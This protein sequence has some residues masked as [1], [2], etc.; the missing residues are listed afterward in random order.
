[1]TKQEH[2]YAEILRAIAD[3][4]EV[5]WQDRHGQWK[6]QAVETTLTEV[7]NDDYESNR[8]RVKPKLININGFYVPEPMCKAPTTSTLVYLAD[9]AGTGLVKQFYAGGI[10]ELMTMCFESGLVHST[11]EAAVIHAKALL[12]FTSNTKE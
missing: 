12:S 6:Y 7:A 5:Q 1:M 9:P 4:E 2:P 11:E 3:G 10:A 8:Y